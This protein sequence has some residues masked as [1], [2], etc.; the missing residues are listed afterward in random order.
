MQ[1]FKNL[2]LEQKNI[3]VDHCLYPHLLSDFSDIERFLELLTLCL[4]GVPTKGLINL[5]IVLYMMLCMV[6]Y[7]ALCMVSMRAKWLIN[8]IMVLCRVLCMVL[9]MV[10]CKVLCRVLCIELCIMH[11][12]VHCVVYCEH[13]GKVVDQ[14]Y[15]GVV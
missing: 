10:L 2:I 6:L 1:G 7:T 11:G 13:E 15:H 4:H 9:Y 8:F 12:V 14:L 3:P 5:I